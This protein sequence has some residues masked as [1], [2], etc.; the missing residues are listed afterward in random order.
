MLNRS[1]MRYK[2]HQNYYCESQWIN[3]IFVSIWLP[4]IN[5]NY[6]SQI[7][8]IQNSSYYWKIEL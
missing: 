8:D 7:F 3:N 2:N 4:C 1:I 6:E 5:K